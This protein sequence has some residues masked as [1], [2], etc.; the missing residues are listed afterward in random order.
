MTINL[1]LSGYPIGTTKLTSAIITISG[2]SG[3]VITI[4]KN[5]SLD[6][7]SNFNGSYV[8]SIN[9]L[10]DIS[11][12]VVV[13]LSNGIE[14]ISQ[15]VQ[16][17]VDTVV[18]IPPILI[19]SVPSI[20]TA[21]GCS[22]SISGESG[23][24]YFIYMDGS[25]NYSLSGLMASRFQSTNFLTIPYGQHS[26]YVKTIDIAQNDSS[27]S[28]VILHFNRNQINR[29]YISVRDDNNINLSGITTHETTSYLTISG[30]VGNFYSITL[31]TVS[32][33]SAYIS[34]S[35]IT[36]IL[37]GLSGEIRVSVVLSNSF[38]DISFPSIT[39]WTIRQY[40]ELSPLITDHTFNSIRNNRLYY[41][42]NYNLSENDRI[43]SL[44]LK[45]CSRTHPCK[46]RYKTYADK[47]LAKRN[48]IITKCYSPENPCQ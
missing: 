38:G 13:T 10:Q 27:S 47:V 9:G 21:S 23:T 2:D 18:P 5:G 11:Y 44:H 12:N 36:V 42:R 16:W 6:V 32:Y 3:T 45:G 39:S 22:F 15:S 20:T 33:Y 24:S 48:N 40:V 30:D 26:F 19:P 29:P 34:E 17:K 43:E 31:N 8:Y 14:E 1:S 4:T 25:S 28:Q 41:G 35:P 7:S 37:S 46:K